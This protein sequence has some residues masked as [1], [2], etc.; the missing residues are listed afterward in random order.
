MFF[1][2]IKNRS[3]HDKLISV[4]RFFNLES[5]VDKYGKINTTI[6]DFFWI[7]MQYYKKYI[8]ENLNNSSLIFDIAL[9]NKTPKTLGQLMFES[10]S[11]NLINFLFN[12]S[13]TQMFI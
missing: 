3:S 5:I 7:L 11:N 8:I 12:I 1:E 13:Q 6:D 4:D 9:V 2:K 10:N